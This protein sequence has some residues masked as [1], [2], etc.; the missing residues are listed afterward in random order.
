M[1][2]IDKCMKAGL[3]VTD[4]DGTMLEGDSL[5]AILS[6]YPNGN[7]PNHIL[8]LKEEGVPFLDFL[9][10]ILRD[11][12]QNGIKIQDIK[13]KLEDYSLTE[14]WIELIQWLVSNDF[15]VLIV[16]DN[17]TFCILHLLSHHGITNNIC[18]SKII[19]NSSTVT[20]DGML[21]VA[22]FHKSKCPMSSSSLCKHAAIQEYISSQK[23]KG[24]YFKQVF[25]AGDGMN[26]FCPASKLKEL[27][28]VFPRCGTKLDAAIS[29]DKD[30]ISAKVIPWDN[31]NQIKDWLFKNML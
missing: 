15:E 4:F 5:R 3:F 13:Q 14:G 24:I 18:A 12:H 8:K 21:Q 9:Q 16:S 26:D 20:E 29:K 27:D 11:L 2:K 7:L 23:E 25:F 1:A 10:A 22:P 19:A 31:G 17:V 30:S 28:V 6:L